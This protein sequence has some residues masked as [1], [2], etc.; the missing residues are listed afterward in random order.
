MLKIRDLTLIR[1]TRNYQNSSIKSLLIEAALAPVSFFTQQKITEFFL[2]DINIDLLPGDRV[3]FI[4]R[5][6]S[7]KSTLCR[8]IAGQLFPSSGTITRNLKV[9]LFSQLEESFFAE[10]TGKENLEFFL[11]AI[12]PEIDKDKFQNIFEDCISFSGLEKR[13]DRPIETYS[14]GMVSRLALSL[15]T[16]HHHEILIL[17]EVHNHADENFRKKFSARLANTIH[18]SQSLIVVSHYFEDLLTSCNRGIVFD[19]GRIIFDGSIEKAVAC[20]KLMPPV[21]HV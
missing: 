5:N 4:G 17:D 19:S 16:A 2:Q 7:G 9:S 8:L 18:G 3:A 14:L 15:L 13:I 20:Y 21:D 1:T 11:H 12:F 6:G 10:L